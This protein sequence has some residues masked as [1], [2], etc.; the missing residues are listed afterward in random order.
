MKMIYIVITILSIGFIFNPAI[1]GFCN[2]CPDN[3]Y[4]NHNDCDFNIKSSPNLLTMPY[5]GFWWDE[6]PGRYEPFFNVQEI[7][8]FGQTAYGLTSADFNNDGLLDFAVSWATSPFDYSGISIFY[9]DGNN[10]FSQDDI[11][12]L[13]FDIAD[14]DSADYDNDGDIDLLFTYSEVFWKGGIPYRWNGTG[15]IL[16]NDGTNHFNNWKTV[17]W[18]KP[19]DEP[20]RKRRINPQVT[21]DD[22]D[23]DGDID[24]LIGDNSGFVEFYKNDGEANFISAGISDFGGEL[25]WGL[26]SADYDNDGDIDFIVTQDVPDK[27]YVFGNI[28]LKWND[29]SEHCFNHNGWIK[30]AD[31]PPYET[32]FS[33]SFPG[34]WGC[35]CSIDYNNDGKMDFLFGGAGV[36]F[37]YIQ[38]ESGIFESFMICRFPKPNKGE[39]MFGIDSLLQGG[40]TVGDFNKDGLDDF[41][42]GGGRGIV[43][44]FYNNFALVDIINPDRAALIRN[45]EFADILPFY[46][47]LKYGTSIVIGNITVM[48]KELVPLSKVEF[49]LDGKLVHT[50]YSTPY[51]WNWNKLSF[52]RH[53]VKV[54]AYDPNGVQV[55][56]D[57]AIVWKFF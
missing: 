26:S 45:D 57:D 31:L 37:L 5:W 56:W 16:L 19:I 25:S 46:P 18:H 7:N 35:L 40:I 51:E 2:S 21:S 39:G 24:F 13:N 32:F 22:F 15:K 54:T 42:T 4:T 50:D 8:K 11:F 14:L 1:E 34:E 6:F 12:F 30:I 53:I 49:Y 44:M 33:A 28:Y 17:F 23:S 29:G 41:V 27:D 43:R 48:A 3:K 38:N 20:G 10:D 55:G 52:G 36:I 9:N 47:F